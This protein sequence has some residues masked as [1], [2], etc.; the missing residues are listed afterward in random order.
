MEELR[1]RAGLC[2]FG[3]ERSAYDWLQGSRRRDTRSAEQL[4]TALGKMNMMPVRARS[5]YL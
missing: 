1:R 4:K 5:R 3:A 2:I